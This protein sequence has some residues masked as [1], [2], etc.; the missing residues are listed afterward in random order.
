M[1][2]IM[3]SRKDISSWSR[4]GEMSRLLMKNFTVSAKH[5]MSEQQTQHGW[6]EIFYSNGI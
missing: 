6:L 2:I 1:E 4:K 3:K 5:T